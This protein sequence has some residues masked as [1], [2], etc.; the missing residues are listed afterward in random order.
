VLAPKFKE[1]QELAKKKAVRD[2]FIQIQTIIKTD[3]KDPVN[4]L[5][6]AINALNV[7]L[8]KLVLR[9]KKLELTYGSVGYDRFNTWDFDY[10]CVDM[11]TETFT[12]GEFSEDFT[13]PVYYD[14]RFY[15]GTVK[16]VR[17][18]IPYLKYRWVSG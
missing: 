4:K 14:C 3:L 7:D 13:Y 5:V 9:K 18:W 12:E 15:S 17:H 8:N 2:G 1:N 16:F 6:K 10:P 11:V